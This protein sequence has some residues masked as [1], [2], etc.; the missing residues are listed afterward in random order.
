MKI[1][2]LFIGK[3]KAE[4]FQD[5][6]DQYIDKLK[7]YTTFEIVSIPYLKNAKNMTFEK[8]KEEEGILI[9]KKIDNTDYVILLDEN[10]KEYTSV[11]FAE[12]IQ[13]QL[14]KGIKNL[15]F[16][17]GGA[18]GF[19]KEVYAR[20]NEKI[21]LSKMTFPHLMTRLIFVEQLYRAFTI[22]K[23]EPYHHI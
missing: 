17:I 21:S 11:K 13:N 16:V 7:Y 10:G 15:I 3:E 18:Y 19:S 5:A 23:N 8:Q 14:N 2:L 20:G 22:L 1:K 6:I 4:E 12:N 9:L